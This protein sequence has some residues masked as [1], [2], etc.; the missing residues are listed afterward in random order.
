MQK[1]RGKRS[2]NS[3]NKT[4]RLKYK[5][6]LATVYEGSNESNSNKSEDY[7]FAKRS[8]RPTFV[9]KSSTPKTKKDKSK[10][11]EKSFLDKVTAIFN[12]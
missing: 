4:Y 10:S 9:K 8:E 3:R 5:P 11:R 7:I 2:S 6:Q 12:F 1:T